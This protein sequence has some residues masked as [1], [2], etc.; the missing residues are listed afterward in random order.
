MPRHSVATSDELW[1]VLEAKAKKQ[2]ISVSRLI[3]EALYA[4]HEDLEAVREDD[5]FEALD[6]VT[7]VV[8][9]SILAI[10]LLAAWM[11]F[12]LVL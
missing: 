4:A 2:G 11:V 10:F 3:R 1:E 5:V 6:K 7:M 12:A 8:T 9:A